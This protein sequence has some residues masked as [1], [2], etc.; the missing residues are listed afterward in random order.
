M[1]RAMTVMA[2]GLS[3]VLLTGCGGGDSK[4]ADD[5][6]RPAA[7]SSTKPQQDKKAKNDGGATR[8]GFDGTWKPINKSPIATM[9]IAGTKVTTTGE[10][11]CPGTLEPGKK[12]SILTLNC[13]TKDSGRA[14]G[15]VELKD[16]THLIVSWDG[17][18]WGGYIDSMRPA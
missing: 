4:K 11:A 7:Q 3:A 13:K 10:L 5:T 1:R 18:A 15:T 14:R 2:L 6:E 9:T 12:E 16:G 8:D 17:A